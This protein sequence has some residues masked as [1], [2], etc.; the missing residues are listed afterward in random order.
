M[1]RRD[2][3]PRSGPAAR[4]EPTF[5]LILATLGR[6]DEVRRLLESLVAQT[7]RSFEL[8]VVDQNPEDRLVP[9]LEHFQE[10]LDIRRIVAPARGL[11]R[12][13]NTGLGHVRG[14]I[15]GFPDD[16]A[17]Y[18]A[19][20]LE[21]IGRALD[22]QPG[23]DGLIGRVT[24]DQGRSVAARWSRRSG[25]VTKLGV[26]TRGTSASMFLRRRVVRQ[27]GEFDVELGLG[28][29]MGSGE[30]TEYLVRALEA[31]ASLLYD[32]AVVVFH[33]RAERRNGREATRRGFQYGKGMGRVLRIHSY[34]FWFVA[35]QWLRAL[36]GAVAALARLDAGAARQHAAALVGRIAGWLTL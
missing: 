24:D 6:I 29:T 28:T 21:R 14:R 5:S 17:W 8:I 33:P 1:N 3:N 22:R 23:L 7:E 19:N 2:G 32:P 18:P 4:P 12:A 11:S 30:E 34:P 10:E 15:V 16:D 35:Y 27:L 26:W 13:R 31:G 9:I 36:G 25:R 20:L